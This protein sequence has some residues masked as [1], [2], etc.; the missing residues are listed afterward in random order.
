MNEGSGGE[1]WGGDRKEGETGLPSRWSC[2]A[3]PERGVQRERLSPASLRAPW[4]HNPEARHPREAGAN[5]APAEVPAACP[6][7]RGC[8]ITLPWGGD[9][10]PPALVQLRV[11]RAQQSIAELG[12]WLRSWPWPDA[13]ALIACGFAGLHTCVATWQ[14]G[15]K[16]LAFLPLSF[17]VWHTLRE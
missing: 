17:K 15:E 1:G 14:R 8:P 3:S 5:K 12:P 9:Q 7:W 11:Q 6:V 16:D 10:H 13:A 4:A 2:K